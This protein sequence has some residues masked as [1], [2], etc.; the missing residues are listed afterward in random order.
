MNDRLLE[1]LTERPDWNV[2][3]QD[4]K[5]LDFFVEYMDHGSL[6]MVGFEPGEDPSFVFTNDAQRYR[7]TLSEIREYV[8]GMKSGKPMDWEVVP[9]EYIEH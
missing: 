6:F 1:I 9:F 5:V 3:A 2:N 4:K 7:F 8:R